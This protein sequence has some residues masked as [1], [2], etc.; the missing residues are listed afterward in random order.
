MR[1][2]DFTVRLPTHGGDGL[3]NEIAAELNAVIDLNEMLAE[4]I[5][6]VARVVGREG[7]MTERVALDETSGSWESEIDTINALI[8]DLVQPTT[9]V[10]R[11]IDRGGRW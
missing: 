1:R 11:V 4:E 5:L 2:G 8:G 9:E 6:R 3:M 7:R 10:A